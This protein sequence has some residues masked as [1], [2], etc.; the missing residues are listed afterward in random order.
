MGSTESIYYELGSHRNTK[1]DWEVDPTSSGGR[2]KVVGTSTTKGKCSN[3]HRGLETDYVRY[4]TD[5]SFAGDS[6]RC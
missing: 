6:P 2:E 4:I 1:V 5:V 3:R